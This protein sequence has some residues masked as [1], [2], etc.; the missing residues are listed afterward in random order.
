[1]VRVAKFQA[2]HGLHPVVDREF[3]FG[4]VPQAYAPL[5]DRAHVGKVVVRVAGQEAR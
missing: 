1:M 5:R 2:Q 4:D 3:D